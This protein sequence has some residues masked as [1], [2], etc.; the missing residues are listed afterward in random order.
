MANRSNKRFAA[1]AVIDHLGKLALHTGEVKI[2]WLRKV[3]QNYVDRWND[4]TGYDCHLER[5]EIVR[6]HGWKRKK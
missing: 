3:A 1:Y 2:F 4:G 5:V 6:N